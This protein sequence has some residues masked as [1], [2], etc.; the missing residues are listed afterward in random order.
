MPRRSVK[1]LTL[2][3]ISTAMIIMAIIAGI[4]MGALSSLKKRGNF[5]SGTGDLIVGL[6]KT[7]AWAFGRGTTAV[8]V[9][10]TAGARFW[11]IEDVNGAFD[12][13]TFN[14]ANPTPAGYNMIVSGTLPIG[15]TFTGATNGYGSALPQPYAGIPSFSGS[16][17]TPNFAYC[18]FCRTA[19]PNTGFGSIQFD[20]GGGARFNAGP[21]AVGQS[22]S[23][24]GQSLS[25]S[26][27]Q[28]VMT[29]AVIA[30]TGTAETFQPL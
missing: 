30:R 10:D 9:I 8:F 20:P 26:G 13:S 6:R 5:A 19:N 7:R 29:F 23:V 27:S 14:P 18:S 3:E 22:F 1:G 12:L 2:I 16:A 28:T 25:S 21:T 24:I 15:V 11:G 4:G 17:A